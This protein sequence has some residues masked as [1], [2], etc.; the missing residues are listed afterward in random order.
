MIVNKEENLKPT[1]ELRI[2]FNY[3]KIKENMLENYLKL[4][5][6]VQNYLSDS[7]HKMFFQADCQGH[8]I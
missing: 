3:R 8:Y 1:D 6:K 2:T 7:R 5:F 4:M